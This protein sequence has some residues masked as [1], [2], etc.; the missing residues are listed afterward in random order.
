[1]T[2]I[3]IN[4]FLRPDDVIAICGEIH[5][6]SEDAMRSFLAA[7]GEAHA[8]YVRTSP[9]MWLNDAGELEPIEET[10]K[11][12]RIAAA[13]NARWPSLFDPLPVQT[14]EI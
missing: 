3:K 10:E 14:P 9:P 12:K 4:R 8:R 11:G 1:M 7:L 2:E 13:L 5:V 6:G